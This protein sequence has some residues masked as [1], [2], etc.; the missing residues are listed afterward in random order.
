[1][2]FESSG[3]SLTVGG[4]RSFPNVNWI[5]TLS[6]V[7]DSHNSEKS[8]VHK[9]DPQL[10]LLVTHLESPILVKLG[11]SVITH[12]GRSPPATNEDNLQ[13]IA[14]E[15]KTYKGSIIVVLGGGAHGH[16]AAQSYGF[17]NP[18]TKT[19]QLLMGIPHIRHNMSILAMEV[20]SVLNN[21]GIP[22]VVISPFA[23][24]TLK[25]NKIQT[26]STTTIE[27]ALESGF[28]VITHGDVC[29]DE[30]KGASILSGDTIAV[31]LTRKLAVQSVYIGTDVDGVLDDNPILNPAAKHIPIIDHSNKEDI[32][33][34]TGPSKNTDVTGGMTKKVN[35]LLEL[36]KQ[37]I[38]IFIFNLTVPGR[39]T[40][41]LSGESTICTRIMP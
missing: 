6:C 31:Y 28:V 10:H 39:L 34:K 15:L 37:D 13:R 20:E 19:E 33:R 26:F 16:Q 9:E 18:T 41:L 12:K 2:L 17:G 8:N 40:S 36:A 5:K 24:S 27:K 21:E 38:D 25:N 23:I 22:T 30:E 35:E 29:F 32:L 3:K 14:K 7:G 11:G 4:V 1:V